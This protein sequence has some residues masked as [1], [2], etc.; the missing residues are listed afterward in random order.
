MANLY[1]PGNVV[2]LQVK[3]QV[4]NTNTDPTGI[5]LSVID[6]SNNRT[7]YTPTHL[8]TGVYTYDLDT[9]GFAAGTWYYEFIGTGTAQGGGA[10]PF[11]IQ[12]KA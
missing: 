12:A 8:A 10:Q 9:T 7:T 6:P 11:Q 1:Y 3:I 5:T 4:A 2:H